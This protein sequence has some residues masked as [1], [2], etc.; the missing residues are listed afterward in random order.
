MEAEFKTLDAAKLE[1]ANDPPSQILK[2]L[3]HG[4]TDPVTKVFESGSL[5]L[6]NIGCCVCLQKKKTIRA[7]TDSGNL[8]TVQGLVTDFD[9]NNLDLGIK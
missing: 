8:T 9:E 1:K 5:W 6:E 2:E 3:S 4:M 7:T